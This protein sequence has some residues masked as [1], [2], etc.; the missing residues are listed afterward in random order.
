MR[1]TPT[2]PQRKSIKANFKNNNEKEK[3]KMAE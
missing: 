3:K 2:K 1:V